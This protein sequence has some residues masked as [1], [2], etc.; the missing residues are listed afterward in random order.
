MNHYTAS[1]SEGFLDRLD[2][3]RKRF[4]GSL[5]LTH[6]TINLDTCD[7]LLNT[8]Y[9][10]VNN[11]DDSDTS[12]RNDGQGEGQ[13][14]ILASMVAKE[15]VEISEN[16]KYA[17]NDDAS[18]YIAHLDRMAV[19]EDLKT[20]HMEEICDRNIVESDAG[21]SDSMMVSQGSGNSEGPNGEEHSGGEQL[22]SKPTRSSLKKRKVFADMT[23]SPK[24][25]SKRSRSELTENQE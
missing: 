6:D 4:E 15:N 12:D 22:L 9:K 8:I 18:P 3:P 19:P 5:D 20:N 25:L 21:D 14:N 17:T 13:T 16:D 1:I 24:R 10:I 23:N 11:V 2:Y 7:T